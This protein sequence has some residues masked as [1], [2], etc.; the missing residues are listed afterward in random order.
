VKTTTLMTLEQRLA[1]RDRENK[2]LKR[3]IARE[4]Q[5]LQAWAEGHL[6]VKDVKF[7]DAYS[8]DEEDEGKGAADHSNKPLNIETVK[9]PLGSKLKKSL[10]DYRTL[11]KRISISNT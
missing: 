8:S 11:L 6:P 2:E 3:V 10:S 7:E 5:V 4:I 9:N 1:E